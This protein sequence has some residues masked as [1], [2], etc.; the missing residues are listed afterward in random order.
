MEPLTNTELAILGLLAEGQPQDQGKHA[1]RIEQDIALRGLRAWTEIGFSSIYY[2]LNKLESAGLLESSLV[3]ESE[4]EAPALAA[5]RGRARQRRGP[6]RRVYRLAPTGWAAY[7]AAV[8]E[9]LARPRPRSA[10]FELGLANLAALPPKDARAA[11][12]ICRA[13]LRE[14]IAGVRAKQEADRA[15]AGQAGISF[16]PHVVALFDRSLHMMQA[17]LDWLDQYL[18]A[19]RSS[20]TAQEQQDEHPTTH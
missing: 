3:D 15:A 9:R 20:E 11:L 19:D 5:G 8:F 18:A 1:Y 7:H 13:D 16:P 6:A 17:E 12:E 10:D 2:V 14:R 4:A